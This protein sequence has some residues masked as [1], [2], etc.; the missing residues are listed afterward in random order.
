MPIDEIMQRW[1]ATVRVLVRHRMLCV[2][3][4]IGT[5]HTIPEICEAH[6]LAEEDFVRELRDAVDGRQFADDATGLANA[7]ARDRC[8]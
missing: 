6:G 8:G 7:P 3:C 4:P 2:G 5:F 1:P